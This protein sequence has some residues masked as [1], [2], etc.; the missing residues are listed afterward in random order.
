[1]P[2]NL[3]KRHKP[4]FM[5]YVLGILAFLGLCLLATFARAADTYAK[6]TSVKDTYA[7]VPAITKVATTWDG[8]YLAALAGYSMS[9]TEL[10][11][12]LFG[13]D[14]EQ[15]FQE[16]IAT[17]DGFGGEGFNF[18]LQLGGDIQVT[19]RDTGNGIVIGGFGE[20]TFGGAESS[21]RLGGLRLD[22]EHG[23]SYAAF[24]TLGY[25]HNN[26]LFYGA[27]G[28]VWTD[29]EV[30]V[31]AGDETL[32]RTFDQTGPAVEAGVRHRFAPGI[33]GKL[34]AR[35]TWMDEVTYAQFGDEEFGGSLKGETGEFEVKAG[36]VISTEAMFGGSGLGIFAGN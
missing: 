12:D 21:A 22:A 2:T 35:Y 27:A 17:V 9:N 14:G 6:Q 26:T 1:M 11:F 34:S 25:A 8:L 10:G 24:G 20:V 31:R 32:R 4:A 18:A 5:I 15:S 23:D 33:Q 28:F 29:V 36:L 30:T 7:D 19:G 16:T 3:P 13:S